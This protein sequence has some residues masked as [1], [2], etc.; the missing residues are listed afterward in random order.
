LRRLNFIHF[1]LGLESLLNDLSN[2]HIVNLLL[3]LE[4]GRTYRAYTTRY[5]SLE[6]NLILLLIKMLLLHKFVGSLL[7]L[8][9]LNLLRRHLSHLNQVIV[10]RE[11]LFLRR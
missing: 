1:H 7:T 6:E 3:G 11:R 8:L 4:L 10:A 9:K 5:I 2:R